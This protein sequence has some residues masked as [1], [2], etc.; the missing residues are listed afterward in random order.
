MEIRYNMLFFFPNLIN[1]EILYT[2]VLVVPSCSG[3]WQELLVLLPLV[4]LPAACRIIY[5]TMVGTLDFKR[6]GWS[7]DFWGFKILDSGIFMRYENLAR[8]FLGWLD[9][10]RE[11][12]GVLKRIR[13]FVVVPSYPS[14]TVLQI[15]YCTKGHILGFD[16]CPHSNI[17]VTWNLQY[18]PGYI[19][20]VEVRYLGENNVNETASILQRCHL[21]KTQRIID[22]LAFCSQDSQV[23][24]IFNPY[25]PKIPI[26]ILQTDLHLFQE[27]LVKRI[28]L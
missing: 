13:R 26:Q 28:C 18:P 15:K 2:K 5:I 17:P 19:Y 14:C 12:L 7:K 27:R 11:F 1:S 6:R 10:S 9:L 22:N 25:S 23:Q 3:K 21:T 8:T 16:F 4:W 24:G 20:R